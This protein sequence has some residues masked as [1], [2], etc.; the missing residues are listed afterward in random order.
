VP[1]DTRFLADPPSSPDVARMY[2]DDL[3]A[4]GYVDNLTHVWAHV[5][6]AQDALV[7]VMR[8]AA[9]AGGLTLRQR[10]L[11]VSATASAFGD[12]YCSLA[13]GTR[14]AGEAGPE[15]AGG[16]LRGDDRLLEPAE[17]ALAGWARSVARNPNATTADD[18]QVLRDAGFD[19]RQIFAI[20]LYVATRIAFSTVND[21][22]GARPDHELLARAPEPVRAAVTF[23]RPAARGPAGD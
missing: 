14:L 18:V 16:V 1:S 20:T 11:L 5:P 12:S 6:S 9:E 21:A 22:L 17:R 19:D 8:Q 10:V 7:E 23:G 3:A 2:A 15:I 13:F 4:S